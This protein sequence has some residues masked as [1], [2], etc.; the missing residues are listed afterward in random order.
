MKKSEKFYYAMLC[1]LNSDYD[2]DIRLDVLEEL[3]DKRE[4]A[5]WCEEREEKE[6]VAKEANA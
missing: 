4:S 5:L 3:M 2:D 6:K 1:V